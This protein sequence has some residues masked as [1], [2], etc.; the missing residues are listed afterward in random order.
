M[1]PRRPP[2]APRVPGHLGHLV[3]VMAL[4]SVAAQP[5]PNV[6]RQRI[7]V[8]T[9]GT[10][11]VVEGEVIVE[12]ADGGLLLRLPD[13]RYE[14][15]DAA[16]IESR[17]VTTA[18]AADDSPRRLG[19]RVL[20]ELPA[21]FDLHLT[22]HYVVCFDTSREYARW[23]AAL[24]E[25]L[26]EAFGNFWSR[27]GL[28]IVDP[29]RPLVVV[30]FSDR[31]AYEAH[32]AGELGRASDRVVGYYNM[33][34]NRVTTFD[35]TG[36]DGVSPPAGRPAGTTGLEILSS[37][38]AA[39]LVSTLVHEAT[40]Q[41]AFNRGM[42]RRLAPV[43][44]WVSEGIAA[45]FETPD[46]AHVRGWSGIGAVNRG[47]LERFLAAHR[48]GDIAA[49][50][51]DDGRFRHADTG[52]D[53]YATAWALT[54][55]LVETRRTAFVAYLRTLAAKPPLAADSP[56]IRLREFEAA[57]GADPAALEQPVARTMAR[58]ATHGR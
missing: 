48:P 56:D 26:H 3:A 22:R 2:V 43:P 37:P 10:P 17:T 53:A 23:C 42:H 30:I 24:F 18:P 4:I 14:L 34:S 38:A 39:G 46:L 7:T 36:R 52:L 35:L 31:Q 13:D 20:A 50:V 45:Y 9:A 32:A 15:L 11:R 29:P 27:A 55:H 49:L 28:E 47:R 40:H 5:L 41:V 58:L 8:R 25:R 33:L 21:G 54:W 44:L 12:A 1:S 6:P 19:Q 16:A 57:F 51:A